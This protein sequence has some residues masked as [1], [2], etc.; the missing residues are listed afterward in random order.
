MGTVLRVKHPLMRKEMTVTQNDNAPEKWSM[1]CPGFHPIDFDAETPAVA[2]ATA[3]QLSGNL[4]ETDEAK[5]QKATR[6]AAQ[7][8]RMKEMIAN[9]QRAVPSRKGKG[10][11]DTES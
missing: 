8:K 10:K 4:R 5:A 7:S 2:M 1:T 11:K 9:G 6:S 3:Q